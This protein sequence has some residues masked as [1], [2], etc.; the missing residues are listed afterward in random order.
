MTTGKRLSFLLIVLVI[1]CETRFETINNPGI[2][3]EFKYK[4][5]SIYDLP[6]ND[7]PYAWWIP[8]KLDDYTTDSDGI[9]VFE[10]NGNHYYHPVQIAQKM[11]H[12]I[13][14]YHRTD[15]DNYIIET[16]RFAEKLV[17]NA[18]TYNGALYFPY[19]FDWNLGGFGI[20]MKAPWYS[21]MAQGQVLS[22]M[23]RL[24]QVTQEPRHL[25][26]CSQI[27]KSFTLFKGLSD[28]WIAYV[29]NDQYYWIEE[30]P[31]LDPNHVLNGFIFAL[32]GLYD[33]YLIDNREDVK[34]YLQAGLTTMAD[35]L[36][37]YRR[38]G[39]YSLYSLKYNVT[40]PDY[41]LVH[42]DQIKYLYEI[43]KDPH[44]IN[45]YIDYYG[46]YHK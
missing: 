4:D 25:E 15:D 40:Y 31:E 14:S 41:H 16:E 9:I 32:F 38:V 22:A 35:H 33:Y 45:L 46:D 3:T 43:T 8:A 27:F 19:E 5:Y 24:Y 7:K 6:F 44:F 39:G 13:A 21:G 23:A 28:P 17:D 20:K 18:L 1:A 34:T 37:L 10:L 11:L 42:T 36:S 12:F 29:D 26:I 2:E 30:Y